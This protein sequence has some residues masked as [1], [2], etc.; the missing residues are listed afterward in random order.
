MSLFQ[1]INKDSILKTSNPFVHL[2]LSRLSTAEVFG[3]LKY[4]KPA[5]MI[6]GTQES[7]ILSKIREK[8]YSLHYS[9]FQSNTIISIFKAMM[10]LTKLI[11]IEWLKQS[12]DLSEETINIQTIALASAITE[13]EI[14]SENLQRKIGEHG[15]KLTN[16]VL[17]HL[18]NPE[19]IT[20]L[21]DISAILLACFPAIEIEGLQNAVTMIATG[22]AT[23]N[24]A[25]LTSNEDDILYPC[26]DENEELV[27]RPVSTS[28]VKNG[29]FKVGAVA[30]V[31]EI[32]YDKS[33][34][35]F[36]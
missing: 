4:K 8:C 5:V 11:Q 22:I 23:L 12:E 13:A 32:I 27:A 21:D 2:L 3:A 16:Q 18:K 35:T 20:Q 29:L 9:E 19:D 28:V 25:L 26:Y 10:T 17:H 1:Y 36:G 31:S 14:T 7:K 24:E 6:E 34:P 15:A 30:S 33:R